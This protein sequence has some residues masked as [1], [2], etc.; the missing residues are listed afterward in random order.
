MWQF[1]NDAFCADTNAQVK[2]Y[3]LEELETEKT[4]LRSRHTE[5]KPLLHLFQQKKFDSPDTVN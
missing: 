3:K 2:R 1:R 5:L 4:S